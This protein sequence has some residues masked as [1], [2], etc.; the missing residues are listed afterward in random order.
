M[1]IM[2]LWR[3]IWRLINPKVMTI[4]CAKKQT[5]WA[6]LVNSLLYFLIFILCLSGYLFASVTGDEINFF[7][8]FY[9]N[10]FEFIFPLFLAD[11]Q[12]QIMQVVHKYS[13]YLLIIL[14][15]LH[16]TAA[17]FHHFIYKNN[18]LK[19]MVHG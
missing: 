3:L 5:Q 11:N 15:L 6:H 16:A 13:A 14:S 4:N 12:E 2:G 1:G 18:T 17:L 7:H 9:F 10:E 8:L 19:R